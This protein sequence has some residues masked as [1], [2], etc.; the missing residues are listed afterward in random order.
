MT[1]EGRESGEKLR[2]VGLMLYVCPKYSHLKGPIQHD[3]YIKCTDNVDGS[4]NSHLPEE[5][6]PRVVSK[7]GSHGRL[8]HLHL[9]WGLV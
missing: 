9:L 1:E 2:K 4:K 8:C 6:A 3:T 7:E 5:E